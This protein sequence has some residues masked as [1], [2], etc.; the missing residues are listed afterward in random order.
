MQSEPLLRKYNVGACMTEAKQT[1]GKN[2][3]QHRSRSSAWT[4]AM[5]NSLDCRVPV[6]THGNLNLSSGICNSANRKMILCANRQVKLA[7]TH[8]D[9]LWR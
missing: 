3:V 8:A 4:D 2:V 1:S 5:E 9:Y 6:E 7:Q